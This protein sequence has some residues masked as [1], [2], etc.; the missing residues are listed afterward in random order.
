MSRYTLIANWYRR[1][2]GSNSYQV[3]RDLPWEIGGKGSGLFVAAPSGFSFD[4]SVPAVL[5]WAFSPHDPQFL[6]AAALHDYLLVSG[7]DRVTAGAVFHAAL[8]A[9]G[10]G[11]LRR[12]L[13]WCA[14]SV[15]KWR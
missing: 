7:W 14:V 4:V 5:C 15:W 8:D 13:M 11:S 1:S 2:A 9:D 3:I 12:G 6:K 10:V